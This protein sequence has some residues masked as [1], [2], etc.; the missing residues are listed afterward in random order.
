MRVSE[1][2]HQT[3]KPK[4]GEV[5]EVP[6]VMT[7]DDVAK[8]EPPAEMLVAG[9]S[10]TIRRDLSH[11]SL[12]EVKASFACV[13]GQYVVEQGAPRYEDVGLISRFGELRK[14]HFA[15]PQGRG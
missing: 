2:I 8:L 13:F 15:R 3:R 7:P 14:R 6:V 9:D 5:I 4:A 12:E 10:H 1:L 11:A